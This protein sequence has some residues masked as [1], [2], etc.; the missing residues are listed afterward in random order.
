MEFLKNKG[1]GT[2]I[3]YP[4]P[5]HLQKCF[6]YLGHKEGDFPVTEKMCKQ[7]LALPIYPELRDD[8]VSSICEAIKEFYNK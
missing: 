5:L 2:S 4:K 1:I 8:E 6:E 3:Y 7:I